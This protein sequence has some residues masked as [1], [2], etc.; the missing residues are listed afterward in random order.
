MA[1]PHQFSD[2]MPTLASL[3]DDWTFP[4]PHLSLA[5]LPDVSSPINE[6]LWLAP[7]LLL[8]PS[9]RSMSTVLCLDL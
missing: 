2:D 9:L 5:F 6:V 1:M 3:L 7:A 8:A 4:P